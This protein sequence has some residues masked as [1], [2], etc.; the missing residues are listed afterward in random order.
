MMGSDVEDDVSEQDRGW[1]PA[2]LHGVG[3]TSLVMS[4]LTLKDG[5]PN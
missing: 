2:L 3:R 5:L 4:F 1:D